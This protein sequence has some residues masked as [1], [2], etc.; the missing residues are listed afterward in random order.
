M[1]IPIKNYLSNLIIAIS[2]STQPGIQ[3][4]PV[5]EELI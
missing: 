1:Q 5:V 2:K 3:M 4:Y